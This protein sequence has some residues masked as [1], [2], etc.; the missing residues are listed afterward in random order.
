M[1]SLGL[2]QNWVTFSESELYWKTLSMLEV[3]SD[4]FYGDGE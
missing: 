4:L 2:Q 3:D 1:F